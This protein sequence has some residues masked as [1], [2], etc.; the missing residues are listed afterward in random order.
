ME[1]AP[2]RKKMKSLL[3]ITGL[4]SCVN[5]ARGSALL[6]EKKRNGGPFIRNRIYFFFL[7][8][9]KHIRTLH[10]VVGDLSIFHLFSLF[11]FDRSWANNAEGRMHIFVLGLQLIELW[12]FFFCL[13]KEASNHS[14]P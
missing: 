13:K 14:S 2:T 5:N 10:I 7:G 12:I 8:V 1:G 11:G 6:R 4:H 9:E 3:Q